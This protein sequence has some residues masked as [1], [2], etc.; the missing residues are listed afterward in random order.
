MTTRYEEINNYQALPT[1][2]E[3]IYT[4]LKFLIMKLK[5]FLL[6]IAV[7]G[8]FGILFTSCAQDDEMDSGHTKGGND[9]D[10]IR[11]T[12]DSSKNEATETIIITT[13][14]FAND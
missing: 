5:H 6:C 12:Q 4:H 9:P 8:S 1:I 2:N 14:V 3:H 13:P 7:I 10:S 11:S